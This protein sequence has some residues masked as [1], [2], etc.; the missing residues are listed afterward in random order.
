[1]EQTITIYCKNTHTYHKVPRGISLIELKDL[2][3]IQ[4]QYPIIAAHVNYKVENLD[5]RLYKPKDVEFLDASTPSGMR[6][7][8]RTKIFSSSPS[9]MRA[10]VRTLNMV[11][12]CAVNEL[13]PEMDLRVEHPI[14]KGYYCT[15][16]WHQ[17]KDSRIEEEKEPPVVTPE[18]VQ[19]IKERMQ[20]IISENRPIIEDERQTKEVIKM[21]AERYNNASSIFEAL[22]NPYCRYFSMGDFIDYYTN[23][24]L[25]SSGYINVFDLEPFKDGLLLRIP[26]RNKPTILEDY[27]S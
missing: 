17:S 5:F 24:L 25:P 27:Y 7:Y 3:G 10:Y 12:A 18:I 15:L 26:N 8:V 21:F 13:F 11:F 4:L 6:A 2:L 19:A 22:G 1:M 16:Q 23:V 20:L 14:S 9:G